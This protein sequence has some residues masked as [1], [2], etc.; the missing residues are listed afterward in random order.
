MRLLLLSFPQ[1]L[2]GRSDHRHHALRQ[3][4]YVLVGDRVRLGM[5]EV[6]SY[7]TSRL[8]ERS[9]LREPDEEEFYGLMS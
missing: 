4:L 9:P 7:P 5:P 3:F 2:V 6:R 1:F 8:T